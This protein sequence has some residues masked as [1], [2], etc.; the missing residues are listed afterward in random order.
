[1]DSNRDSVSEIIHKAVSER[2]GDLIEQMAAGAMV[3]VG[4]FLDDNSVD[5]KTGIAMAIATSWASRQ[6]PIPSKAFVESR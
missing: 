2:M 3:A 6:H 5:L 4:K 1:M